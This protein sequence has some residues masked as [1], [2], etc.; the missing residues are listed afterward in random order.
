MGIRIDRPA[1]AT[2]GMALLLALCAGCASTYPR[3]LPWSEGWRQGTVTEVGVTQESL[4]KAT[5]DCR[6][7]LPPD[8]VAGSRFIRV[9]YKLSQMRLGII[10]LAG[11]KAV[12]TPGASVFVH[13]KDCRVPA[14]MLDPH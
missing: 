9:V 11:E 2:A 6:E 13:V 10:S 8:V 3:D 7:V 5:V 12:P 4:V 1:G 14:R